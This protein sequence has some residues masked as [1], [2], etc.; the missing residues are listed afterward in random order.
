[1]RA[2]ELLGYGAAEVVGTGC[3]SAL[4]LILT[5]GAPLCTP[6]CAAKLCF[7]RCLPYTAQGCRCRHKD[8]HW[9]D[10]DL[11]SITIPQNSSS[12]GVLAILF[13]RPA[14][15]SAH[16][17]PPS[18]GLL[19]IFTL[20]H[21]GFVADSGGIDS[22]G[23]HRKQALTILKYLVT[24]R[25]HAIH[26]EVLSEALW[27]GVLAEQGR[28]RLK[29]AVHYLRQRFRQAGVEQPVIETRQA[30]YAIRQDAVWVD[31]DAFESLLQEAEGLERRSGPSQ[32]LLRYQDA[33]ALY[34]GEYLEEEPYADWCGIERER[35]RE[36]YLG[37]LERM[38]YLYATLGMYQ[39]AAQ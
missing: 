6:D 36:R 17:R 21:F 26:V 38:A 24:H 16:T 32:A 15:G 8:G 33:E 35:L 27:P 19:R 25:G 34:R 10:L 28:G 11:S 18:T 23:W 29:V 1:M 5:S 3:W 30:S 7:S 4:G 20:G 39:D 37:L 12:D 22:G 14:Q 2:E 13:L 9:V 31:A